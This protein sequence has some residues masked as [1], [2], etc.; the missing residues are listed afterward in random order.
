MTDHTD[1]RSIMTTARG[2]RCRPADRQ[3]DGFLHSVQQTLY[4]FCYNRVCETVSFKRY[5]HMHLSSSMCRQSLKKRH[6]SFSR[7]PS[8]GASS[9]SEETP[10]K[11][12]DMFKHIF[13][14][15]TVLHIF[16]FSM[17]KRFMCPCCH[18]YISIPEKFVLR[19]PQ[20]LLKI[21]LSS[22]H[23]TKLL[24]HSSPRDMIPEEETS[25]DDDESSNEESSDEDE[26]SGD[27]EELVEIEDE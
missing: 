10:E 22:E 27:D 15:T 24:V 6:H 20:T 13:C 9:A 17:S 11:R 18:E 3:D 4:D 25:E 2:K 23:S 21:L 14:E 16:G 26:L 7:R 19:D 5:A 8:E 1:P 12:F